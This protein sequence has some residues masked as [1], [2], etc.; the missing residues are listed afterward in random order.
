MLNG[1][2]I[3]PYCT[4]T[5]TP[6]YGGTYTNFQPSPLGDPASIVDIKGTFS[7]QGALQRHRRRLSNQPCMRTYRTS[8]LHVLPRE[9]CRISA[10]T[11][12]SSANPSYGRRQA[13]TVWRTRLLTGTRSSPCYLDCR[14]GTNVHVLH[15]HDSAVHDVSIDKD[16]NLGGN[17]GP[18]HGK[19]PGGN[20]IHHGRCRVPFGPYQY[21]YRVRSNNRVGSASPSR[22]IRWDRWARV[23]TFTC[24]D[25]SMRS[26]FHV[27]L[28]CH[29]S[30]RSS[31]CRHPV[32]YPISGSCRCLRTS[33]TELRR[34]RG[35][36]QRRSTKHASTIWDVEVI[37]VCTTGSVTSSCARSWV[38]RT[39]D[40]VYLNPSTARKRCTRREKKRRKHIIQ[41]I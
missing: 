30:S 32:R 6:T 34:S 27:R 17:P 11:K 40:V 14:D 13:A 4:L 38:V 15:H 28:A 31:C 5:A 12:P 21:S 33:T 20:R 19:F 25:E 26:A 1:I 37:R 22:V 9:P 8:S 41:N 36:G 16:G 39:R 29:P 2:L 18:H 10:T 7:W 3:S 35:T 23:R 24:R